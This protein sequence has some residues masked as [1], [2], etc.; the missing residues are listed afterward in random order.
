M[1]LRLC[2]LEFLQ[3]RGECPVAPDLRLIAQCLQAAPLCRQ[4]LRELGDLFLRVA[5]LLLMPRAVGR[6][7]RRGGGGGGHVALL[8]QRDHIAVAGALRD[9]RRGL[10]D[11]VLDVDRAAGAQQL[12]DAAQLAGA[13]RVV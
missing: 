6:R 8:Q 9:V 12:F 2:Q 4:R 3:Q 13:A 5:Q 10:A 1:K 11:A 7:A